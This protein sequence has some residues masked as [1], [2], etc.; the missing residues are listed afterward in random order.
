[1]PEPPSQRTVTLPPLDLATDVMRS[2]LVA[3]A[4]RAV[5]SARHTMK[6]RR[7][8]ARTRE[9]GRYFIL[10]LCCSVSLRSW[11]FCGFGFWFGGEGVQF[12]E[13]R[14]QIERLLH[15]IRRHRR[16]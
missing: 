4:G 11:R 15:D 5:A 7:A 12:G 1:M 3:W 16:Q 13:Q 6:E 14:R 9:T 10:C 2:E 8:K